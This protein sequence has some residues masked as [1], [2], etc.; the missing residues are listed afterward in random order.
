MRTS[1]GTAVIAILFLA[2]GIVGMVITNSIAYLPSLDKGYPGPTVL[3][4]GF[5]S[6]FALIVGLLL[7]LYW[8][9]KQ[10]Y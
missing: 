2:A 10:M 4:A 6:A 9:I 3:T 1:I 7:L 5:I 8:L